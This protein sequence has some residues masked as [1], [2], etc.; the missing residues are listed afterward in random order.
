MCQVSAGG[1]HTL[2]V[3][4]VGE[5]YA[6]GCATNGRL[7]LGEDVAWSGQVTAPALVELPGHARVWQ[8]SAGGS[9]SLVIATDGALFSWG[10][11]GYGQ[12]GHGDTHDHYLPT[13]VESL[14]GT[15][16]RSIEASEAHSIVVTDPGAV[17]AFGQT[18]PDGREDPAEE[19]DVLLPTA[20]A[21]LRGVG[22]TTVV[23]VA[24]GPNHSVA[25]LADGTL[26]VF[27]SNEH[28]QLG[29]NS[30]ATA[31]NSSEPRVVSLPPA[32]AFQVGMRVPAWH[33]HAAAT[34]VQ[35]AMR[36]GLA[37]TRGA[38]KKHVE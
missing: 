26:R 25:M 29:T 17:L 6:W 27:G 20:I 35:A 15:R 21:A 9:H 30:V 1:S 13:E 38:R 3:S 33:R 18:Q 10:N 19:V 36:G 34:A 37:R 22:M 12:L 5:L 32:S 23:G 7:G 2:A 31:A 8:A 28:G 4:A 11:G 14:K 16:I 24:S